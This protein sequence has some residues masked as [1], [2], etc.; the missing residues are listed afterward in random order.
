MNSSA[1]E[2]VGDEQ[3]RRVYDTMGL[4]GDE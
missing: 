2:T 1:Y 3:K 4:T